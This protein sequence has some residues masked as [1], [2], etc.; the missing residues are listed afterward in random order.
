MTS[1]R[2]KLFAALLA[3]SCVIA[4]PHAASAAFS[5]AAELGP[6][7]VIG[8]A[9]VGDDTVGFGVAA[10]LGYPIS[11]PLLKISPELKVGFDRLPVG[12]NVDMIRVMG[13][14]RA[15]LLEGFS[16]IAFAHVGYGS[17]SAAETGFELTDCN[18]LALDVGG[19]L[20]F[21]LLPIID[22]GAYVAW[23]TLRRDGTSVDWI[24]LGAQASLSF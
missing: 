18:G 9:A 24:S 3:A 2:P 10:R 15:T 4:T 13:G 6:Q 8:D 20:D 14:A 19:G 11:I 12:F 22:V 21:T 23:N 5:I 1:R 7:L 16:P 17:C